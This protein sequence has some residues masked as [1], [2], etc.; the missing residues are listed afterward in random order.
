MQPVLKRMMPYRKRIVIGQSF[1]FTE[2][3]L[4]LIVPLLIA[5]MVDQGILVHSQIWLLYRFQLGLAV[6]VFAH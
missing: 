4:E 5:Q 2:V 6:L 3:I 1:K